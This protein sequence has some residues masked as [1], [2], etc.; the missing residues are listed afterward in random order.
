MDVMGLEAPEASPDSSVRFCLG[1]W[2][3]L[4][5]AKRTFALDDCVELCGYFGAA[6]RRKV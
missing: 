5:V 6:N 3:A 1:V 2:A 4:M